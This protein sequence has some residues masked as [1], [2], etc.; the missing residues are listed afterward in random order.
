MTAF[1]GDSS[2]H[3]VIEAGLVVAGRYQLVSVLGAG[4]MGTVWSATHLGLNHLVA[5][6]IISQK[7][8]QSEEARRRFDQEAKAAARLKSRYVVQ[9]FDNGELEDGTPYMAMEMLEG[10]SLAQRLGRGPMALAEA[11][12]CLDEVGRAIDRAHALGIIHR[13]LKPENI[14]L[15]R[16]HDD[17]GGVVVKVLDFGIAKIASPDHA[18]S[19]TKTG[20]FLGTPLFMSPEQARGLKSLDYRSDLYSLGLVVYTMLTRSAPFQ[21]ESIGDLIVQICSESLP[22]FVGRIPQ[23][24]GPLDAWLGRACHRDPQQR[25]GTAR[26]MAAAF[27]LAASLGTSRAFGAGE[28]F[29]TG[30]LHVTVEPAF[31]GPRSAHGQASRVSPEMISLSGA[32]RTTGGRRPRRVDVGVLAGIVIGVSVLGAAAFLVLTKKA[33]ATSSTDTS[34][35]D[36]PE[37]PRSSV[38]A[39]TDRSPPAVSSAA[40]TVAEIL[41]AGGSHELPSRKESSGGARP[42]KQ[43]SAATSERAPG[44][45]PPP[46][47]GAMTPGAPAS[48]ATAKPKSGATTH[49]V[50]VGF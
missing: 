41:D 29:E 26:E 42:S 32:S 44:P 22:S 47:S 34:V 38:S 7:F 2:K 10:E 46:S 4:G 25:F 43:P 48:A 14:F 15:A 20:A 28:S 36:R 13:D 31:P 3:V 1:S 12:R 37:P 5:L 30:G 49:D 24:A 40:P 23:S 18:P 27:V 50:E 8:A 16:S 45:H 6:K 11:A 33:P 17:E 39:S 21:G 19:H 35:A 9:V